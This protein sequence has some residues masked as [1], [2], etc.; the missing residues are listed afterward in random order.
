MPSEVSIVV[1]AL[2]EL[3]EEPVVSL[4]QDVERARIMRELYLTERDGLLEEHPWNFATRRA[5]LAALAQ[6]PVFGFARAFALPA[7]CLAVQDLEPAGA[8]YRVEAGALLTDAEAVALRYVARVEDVSAMPPSFRAT[9]A[10]RLA[11][12]A[13]RKLTGS[14]AE[15]ERLEAL[16]RTRLATAK[17]CDAQGGGP[18]PSPRADGLLRSRI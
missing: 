7:D 5:D 13:A 8:D 3:G 15:K 11:A 6:A 18:A 9:L 10:A 14:G 16:Y 17:G 4:D 1:S 12:K 2:L